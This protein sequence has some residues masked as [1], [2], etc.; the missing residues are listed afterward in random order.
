[1]RVA[2]SADGPNLDAK[3]DPRFGRCSHFV[4]VDTDTLDSRVLENASAASAQGAGIGTAQMVAGEGV[5]VVLTGNCG[6][7]A[8][9]AL[10]AAGIK[11]VTGVAG[12]VREAVEAYKAGR[13]Q[14][15][16]QPNVASHFGM[17]MGGGMGRGMGGGMGRQAAPPAAASA[18]SADGGLVDILKELKVQLDGLREQVDDINR[19]IEELHK[20]D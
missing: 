16:S 2:V 6:P 17:G 18:L 15:S 12:T 14:P 4:L 7:N 19:R 1:L 13:Y 20:E 9:Q 10:E 8:Y 3:V 5:G 11:V